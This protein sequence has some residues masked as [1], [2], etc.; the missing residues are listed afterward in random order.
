I[1]STGFNALSAEL[2]SPNPTP[3]HISSPYPFTGGANRIHISTSTPVPA[4]KAENETVNI[5][6]PII[7]PSTT[8][9]D[10]DDDYNKPH[11]IY[12]SDDE[13][14]VLN[15]SVHEEKQSTDIDNQN[16]P[17]ESEDVAATSRRSSSASSSTT[18]GEHSM[19]EAP[20][21][22]GEKRE[23][24]EVEVPEVNEQTTEHQEDD[25]A[26]GNDGVEVT[27]TIIRTIVVETNSPEKVELPSPKIE[28][29]NV[30]KISRDVHQEVVNNDVNSSSSDEE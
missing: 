25:V 1:I 22:N 7:T 12:V 16:S 30:V 24:N 13:D 29:E 8:G 18:S 2:G 23:E 28:G 10:E 4:L 5:D 19:V 14:S 9:A 6:T 26:N 20:V 15:N 27:T 11:F 3:G 21:T 17:L